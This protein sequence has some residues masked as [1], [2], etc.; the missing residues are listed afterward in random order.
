MDNP[1]LIS[2][3]LCF[4]VDIQPHTHT[5]RVTPRPA[6]LCVVVRRCA[7][8]C[9]VVRRCAR[10]NTKTERQRA[11]RISFRASFSCHVFG[12]DEHSSS[13]C[14][15]VRVCVCGR[16]LCGSVCVCGR[17]RAVIGRMRAELTVPRAIILLI[18]SWLA[19][20][21]ARDSL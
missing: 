5:P 21:R 15:F 19:V 18:E 2:S 9:V 12:A 4:G 10:I 8:L 11:F 16:G 13:V 17:G 1:V 6:L 14:V 3:L 7:S 20:H